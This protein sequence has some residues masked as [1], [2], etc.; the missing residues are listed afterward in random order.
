MIAFCKSATKKPKL[1]RNQVYTSSLHA[2]TG[3]EDG[4]DYDATK[5]YSSSSYQAQDYY[6]HSS[7]ESNLERVL[8]MAQLGKEESIEWKKVVRS[9]YKIE[10][11]EDEG[12]VCHLCGSHKSAHTICRNCANANSSNG[13]AKTIAAQ[14]CASLTQQPMSNVA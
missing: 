8:E 12:S 6:H 5:R 7:L 1:L 13:S 14:T 11:H 10:Y 3:L 9:A 2:P 4:T